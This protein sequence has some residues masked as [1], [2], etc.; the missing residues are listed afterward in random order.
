MATAK[1][2]RKK[3]TSTRRDASSSESQVRAYIASQPEHSRR[4]LKKLRTAIRATAPGA[5]ESFGYRIPGFRLDGR[6]LVYYAGWREHTSIY[7]ITAAIQR[8]FARELKGYETSKGTVR[9]P[10][11]RPLPLGLVKRLV[12]AR[13]AEARA[14]RKS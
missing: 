2:K 14:L 1:T 6:T 8:A 12:K 10:L 11:S 3:S 13:V 4:E 7:P 5:V 9:F